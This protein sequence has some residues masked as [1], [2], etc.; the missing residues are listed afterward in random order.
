MAVIRAQLE[1]LGSIALN[2]RSTCFYLGFGRRYGQPVRMRAINQ[3]IVQSGLL[4]V[5]IVTLLCGIVGVMLAIQGM[6]TLAIFG[7][8]QFISVGLAVSIPKEFSP[9]IVGIVV[10]GRSGSQ[11][12]S[13]I[14]SMRLNGELDGLAV[15]GISPHRFVD[16]PTLVGLVISVPLLVVIGNFSALLL[17]GL[18]ASLYLGISF[19][20]YLAQLIQLIELS[21]YLLGISKGFVF[22]ILIAAIGLGL[23]R[24]VEGGADD[25]G[26]KTTASVVTCIATIIAVDALYSI[27]EQL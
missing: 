15:M 1:V 21:D 14:G 10:A 25:L 23:G 5:P 4:A 3:Q 19:E 20:A 13:R 6:Q 18:Y 17:S 2:L 9:L 8:E 12:T 11:I 24:R 26:R 7:A 16:A 22:A 27:L